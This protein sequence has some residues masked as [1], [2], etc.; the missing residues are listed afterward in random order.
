VNADHLAR[1]RPGGGQRRR[2]AWL[3]KAAQWVLVIGG[4]VVTA[5]M[6]WLVVWYA[7]VWLT[8]MFVVSDS[9]G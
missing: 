5:T 6:V 2:R 1:Q 9:A 7:V 4:L 8:S 3:T